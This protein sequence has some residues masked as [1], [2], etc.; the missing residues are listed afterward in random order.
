M[1]LGSP[2]KVPPPVTARGAK[3]PSH[4]SKHQPGVYHFRQ[5]DHH[6]RR[7]SRKTQRPHPDLLQ[8]AD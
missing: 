1:V 5:A 3:G 2:P 4:P 7:P 6:L 8:G